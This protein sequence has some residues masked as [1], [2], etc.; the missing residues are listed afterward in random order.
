MLTLDWKFLC[1]V[2]K[3]LEL[4]LSVLFLKLRHTSSVDQHI[5]DRF[6]L[7]VLHGLLMCDNCEVVPIYLQHGKHVCLQTNTGDV[8]YHC[9]WVNSIEVRRYT[10]TNRVR[11]NI[12]FE[13]QYQINSSQQ[14]YHSHIQYFIIFSI[15]YWTKF[16]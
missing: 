7:N 3:W 12:Q 15:N 13:Q 14:M 2:S 6:S 16:S 4:C 8:G 11:V 5:K 9:Q 10:R 1:V